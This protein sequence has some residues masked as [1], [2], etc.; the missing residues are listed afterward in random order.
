[1]NLTVRDI[2]PDYVYINDQQIPHE[3][4]GTRS[5]SDRGGMEVV[6]EPRV[7]PLMR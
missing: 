2:S 6:Y 4:M 3:I 1:M 5:V 7:S